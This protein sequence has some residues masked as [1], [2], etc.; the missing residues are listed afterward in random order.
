MCRGTLSH[1]KKIEKK[2]NPCPVCPSNRT[3][4]QRDGRENLRDAQKSGQAPKEQQQESAGSQWR[5]EM[6]T[7]PSSNTER[8]RKRDVQEIVTGW[9]RVERSAKHTHFHGQKRLRDLK[10]IENKLLHLDSVG[11]AGLHHRS[12][13]GVE[14]RNG[15]LGNMVPEGDGPS[16]SVAPSLHIPPLTLPMLMLHGTH[17]QPTHTEH[18][19]SHTLRKTKKASVEKQADTTF[20]NAPS[21]LRISPGKGPKSSALQCWPD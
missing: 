19:I 2:R 17:A 11:G 8:E 9:R 16:P 1:E 6:C 12:R 3:S 14:M 21:T 15:F 20:G 7:G 4:H 10:H 5:N 18:T 13:F